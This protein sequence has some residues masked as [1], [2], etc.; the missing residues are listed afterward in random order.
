[1]SGSWG[2]GRLLSSALI[3]ALVLPSGRVLV[4]FVTPAALEQAAAKAGS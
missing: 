2:S 3:N 1:V 4:G